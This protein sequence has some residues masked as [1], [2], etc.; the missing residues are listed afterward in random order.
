MLTQGGIT[1][2]NTTYVLFALRWRRKKVMSYHQWWK[3]GGTG[4]SLV[5]R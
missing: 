2:L 3:G 4:S 5:V 1:L